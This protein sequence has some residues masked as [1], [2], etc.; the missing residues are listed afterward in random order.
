VKENEKMNMEPDMATGRRYPKD[1]SG[2]VMEQHMAMKNKGFY[3]H[4]SQ[5]DHLAHYVRVATDHLKETH[6]QLCENLNHNMDL[7]FKNYWQ[8]FMASSLMLMVSELSEALEALRKGDRVNMDEELADVF[9][10]LAD[11]CGAHNVDLEGEVEKKMAKNRKRDPLHG[12][13]F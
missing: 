3:D 13:K 9:L 5:L 8:F 12:K 10:R 1:L 4:L 7:V 11:F 2:Y 6:P